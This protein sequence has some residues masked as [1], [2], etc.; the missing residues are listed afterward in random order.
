MEA[1]VVLELPL[2]P[3]FHQSRTRSLPPWETSNVVV[4]FEEPPLPE[5]KSTL[6]GVVAPDDDRGPPVTLTSPPTPMFSNSTVLL[7]S[8]FTRRLDC[9]SPNPPNW[10][11][12]M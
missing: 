3:S 9:V 11:W 12:S 5:K 4:L 7:S 1:N 10:A 2:P 8:P 6:P